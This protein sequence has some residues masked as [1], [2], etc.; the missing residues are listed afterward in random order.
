MPQLPSGRRVGLSSDPVFD[1]VRQGDWGTNFQLSVYL[2]SPQDMA[3]LLNI[4]YYKP[5]SET[6][7]AMQPYLSGLMLADVGTE[8]CDWPA[9]DVQFFQE[10]LATELARQWLKNTFQDLHAA[11]KATHAELPEVLHGVLEQ[12]D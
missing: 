2:E 8:K 5:E 3:P 10:W 11:L 6:G 1:L 4:I 7:G 9:E 12:E